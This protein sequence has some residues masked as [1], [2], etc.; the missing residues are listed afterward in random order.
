VC[1]GALANWLNGGASP[2]GE[3]VLM[4]PFGLNA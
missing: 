2:T 4:L 1:A 3:Y